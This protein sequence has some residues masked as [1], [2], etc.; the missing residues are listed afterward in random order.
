[1]VYQE[2]FD[3]AYEIKKQNTQGKPILVYFPTWDAGSSISAYWN[4][5]EKLRKQFFIVTKAHHCTFRLRSE[6]E[7]RD[8]LY[9]ISDIVCGGNFDFKKVASVG[10]VAV[11]DAISGAAAEVPLLN[12]NIDMLLL[13]YRRKMTLKRAC[14]NFHTV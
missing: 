11:C 1:M 10:D 8:I 13:Y 14:Q 12:P 4:E 3:L 6:Q 5:I 2:P 9:R 7:H